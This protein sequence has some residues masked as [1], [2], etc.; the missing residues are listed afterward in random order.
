MPSGY[1]F[2]SKIEL[3]TDISLFCGNNT[4][5]KQSWHLRQKKKSL[6][7]GNPTDRH[8][9]FGT[10]RKFLGTSENFYGI[11]N[12]FYAFPIHSAKVLIDHLKISIF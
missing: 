2:I 7:S 1:A 10:Y 6:V 4:G 11:F 3:K 5:W 12:D 8:H 9:F